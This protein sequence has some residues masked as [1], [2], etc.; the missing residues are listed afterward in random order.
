MVDDPFA[1]VRD[2]ELEPTIQGPESEGVA[3]WVVEGAKRYYAEE[4]IDPISVEK[5][6][7]FHREQVDPLKPLIGELFDFDDS[8]PP[9]TRSAFNAALKKWRDVNGDQSQ[10]FKPATV[11]KE[12]ERRGVKAIKSDGTFVLRGI[13]MLMDE[14]GPL[15]GMDGSR[16]PGI[17]NP[18]AN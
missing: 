15:S 8:A 5:A 12:L 17:L 4:L 13:R 7:D 6:T 3:A 1:D 18:D 11:H 16:N 2:R 9:I 14:M 10:K